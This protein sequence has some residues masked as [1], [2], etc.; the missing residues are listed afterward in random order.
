MF[1]LLSQKILV[2]KRADFKGFPLKQQRKILYIVYYV[3]LNKE[4]EKKEKF[5]KSVTINNNF[6]IIII[7]E[8]S[9]KNRQKK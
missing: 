2:I 7:I 3:N 4:T 1:K 9:L 6:I 8:F 5:S